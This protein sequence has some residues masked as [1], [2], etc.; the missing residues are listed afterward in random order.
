MSFLY[1][2]FPPKCNAA[3]EN[4]ESADDAEYCARRQVGLMLA[5]IIA[6]VIVVMLLLSGAYVPAIV[7][8]VGCLILYYIIPKLNRYAWDSTNEEIQGMIKRDPNMTRADALKIIN[9]RKN[10]ERLAMA[11]IS[12]NRYARLPFY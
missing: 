11:M 9:D 8:A 10:S 5:L 4:L 12:N 1:S 6:A 7:I 3:I 2:L